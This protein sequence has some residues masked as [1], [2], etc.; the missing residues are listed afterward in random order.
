[1]ENNSVSNNNFIKVAIISGIVILFALFISYRFY[2]R[3]N[4]KTAGGG[5]VEQQTGGAGSVL[6]E[7]EK[8]RQGPFPT[9]TEEEIK[10]QEAVKIKVPEPGDQT[11]ENVAAP[12]NV[13]PAAPGIAAKDRTFTIQGENGVFTPSTIIVKVGDTVRLTINAVDK[14]YDFVLPD[15]GF[16][17]QPIAAGASTFLGFQA[18]NSGKFIF[19]CKLC[20]GVNSTAKG[21][22][23]VAP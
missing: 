8:A 4:Q 22:L 20:G 15:Y 23:I 12:T 3:S 19:Y 13:Q 18:L 7:A 17:T 2:T 6:S 21:E 9:I 1:M 14:E 10:P 16:A 11:A 5:T